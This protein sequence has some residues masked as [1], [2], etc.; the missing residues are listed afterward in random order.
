LDANAEWAE[1]RER[2]GRAVEVVRT[3]SG[4][5]DFVTHDETV[6]HSAQ[7]DSFNLRAIF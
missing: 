1:I 5:F 7:D 4:S 6:S 3:S 2:K